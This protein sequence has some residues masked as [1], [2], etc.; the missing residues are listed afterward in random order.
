MNDEQTRNK[1]IHIDQYNTDNHDGHNNER[2]DKEEHT[3]RVD[4]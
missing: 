4:N 2:V 1:E 3:Q